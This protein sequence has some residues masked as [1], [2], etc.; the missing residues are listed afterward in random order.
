MLRHPDFT[1]H[2]VVLSACSGKEDGWKFILTFTFSALGQLFI[3][4]TISE[5][6]AVVFT[7]IMTT[8]SALGKKFFCKLKI[9][10]LFFMILKF[11]F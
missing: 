5:F 8:R 7:I 4:Y 11:G 6:G 1:F 9:F 2:A 3:Y 10:L